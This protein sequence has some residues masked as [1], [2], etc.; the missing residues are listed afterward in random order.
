V[1]SVWAVEHS[2][3]AHR[4]ASIRMMDA[5]LKRRIDGGEVRVHLRECPAVG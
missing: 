1:Q 5:E 3:R 4:R 2:I